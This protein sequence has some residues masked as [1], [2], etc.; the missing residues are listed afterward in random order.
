MSL[1][2]IGC[3]CLAGRLSDLKIS[4]RASSKQLGL[5]AGDPEM[6]VTQPV[7]RMKTHI[8]LAVSPCARSNFQGA[9]PV[10]TAL[11]LK[12]ELIN[13]HGWEVS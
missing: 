9:A 5:S 2:C 4:I 6:M 3:H 13:N 10:L 11:R 1:A 12:D 8:L 7:A